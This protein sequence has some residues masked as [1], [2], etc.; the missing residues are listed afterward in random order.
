MQDGRN[1]YR[2]LSSELK[3]EESLEIYKDSNVYTVFP[4]EIWLC[5]FT[6]IKEKRD[7]KHLCLVCTQFY[8]TI[9]PILWRT[10]KLR[11]FTIKDFY[12]IH[13]LPIYELDTTKFRNNSS[14]ET[15]HRHMTFLF[16]RLI[17]KMSLLRSLTLSEIVVYNESRVLMELA[18]LENIRLVQCIYSLTRE[19]IASKGFFLIYDIIRSIGIG[20]KKFTKILGPEVLLLAIFRKNG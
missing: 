20:T 1:L 7:M 9:K 13:A 11:R 12:R 8:D 3:R 10:P 2:M 15:F 5:I 16:F 4:P 19:N 18:K 14:P 6:Y 17:G